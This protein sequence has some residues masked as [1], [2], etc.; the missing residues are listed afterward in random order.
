MSDG[1]NN[2]YSTELWPVPG[3]VNGVMVSDGT[4]W[5][6]ATTLSGLTFVAPVLGAAT[7]TTLGLST[8]RPT[9]GSGTGVTVNDAGSLRTQV[10]KVTVAKENFVTAGV[11]HDLTIATLPAKTVVHA[12]IAD[13][14]EAFA[15]ASTCTTGTLSGTV[16]I[17][18]GGVEFLESFDMDAGIATFGDT[19]AEVGSKL[20]VAGATNS[21]YISWAGTAVVFRAVSG[22]GNW[23]NTSATNLSAGAVTFYI[24][25]S[26]LP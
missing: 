9:P 23:G 11:N 21:G 26:V 3:A 5:T 19:D 14:T 1:T 24:L 13:V 7:G 20:D 22:T 8:P 25:Y 12:V 18:A 17:T 15:C 10:Y 2:V 6:R 16:G 4:D